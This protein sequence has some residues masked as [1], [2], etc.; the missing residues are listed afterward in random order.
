MMFQPTLVEID[1]APV[2][3][4]GE[5]K[6]NDELMMKL[7]FFRSQYPSPTVTVEVPFISVRWFGGDPPLS[8]K[9]LKSLGGD[10]L[11]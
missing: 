8:R 2:V 10:P 11:R 9:I 3:V 4:D 5:G 1:T 6:F 7:F